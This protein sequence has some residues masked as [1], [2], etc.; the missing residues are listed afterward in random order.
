ML[1]TLHTTSSHF[2]QLPTKS[3]A[4]RPDHRAGGGLHMLL[5]TIL[6]DEAGDKCSA[7]LCTQ[8]RCSSRGEGRWSLTHLRV[9]GMTWLRNC[10]RFARIW[11]ET[12]DRACRVFKSRELDSSMTTLRVDSQHTSVEYDGLSDSKRVHTDSMPI[13]KRSR[14]HRVLY[15]YCPRSPGAHSNPQPPLQSA[16]S[17]LA[18]ASMRL[19]IVGDGIWNGDAGLLADRQARLRARGP[20]LSCHLSQG[21]VAARNLLSSGFSDGRR[22]V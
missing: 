20:Q 7:E 14:H 15:P 1:H 2:R 13:L 4:H 22:E 19:D 6:S 21:C 5:L 17:A 12:R 11:R 10:S 18:E 9:L 8:F 16:F 3:L